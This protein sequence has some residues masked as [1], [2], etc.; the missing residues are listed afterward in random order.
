M[1]KLDY[2][3]P[4]SDESFHLDK[5]PDEV[6]ESGEERV[7]GDAGRNERGRGICSLI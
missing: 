6:L 5:L 3:L 2:T 1:A 4:Y 7:G